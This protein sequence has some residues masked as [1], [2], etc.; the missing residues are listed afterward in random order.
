MIQEGIGI[1]VV[2]E[3]IA[4]NYLQKMGLQCIHLLDDWAERQFYLCVNNFSNQK[5]HIQN[6]LNIL[7]R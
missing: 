4:A 7:L 1:G 5:I 2:P 6:L 3:K